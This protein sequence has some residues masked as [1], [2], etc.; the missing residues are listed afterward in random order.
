MALVPDYHQLDIPS[1]VLLAKGLAR[2]GVTRCPPACGAALA[3]E[4]VSGG[5]EIDSVS[6]CVCDV[7][8]TWTCTTGCDALSFCV[9][10][11]TGS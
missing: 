5:T 10:S 11:G 8:G 7:V 6:V 2:L 1:L 9:W 4:G 3:A